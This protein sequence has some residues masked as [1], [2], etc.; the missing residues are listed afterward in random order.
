[1]ATSGGSEHCFR[2]AEAPIVTTVTT[3]SGQPGEYGTVTTGLGTFHLALF[4]QPAEYPISV[5]L[6]QHWTY[7][8]TLLERLLREEPRPAHTA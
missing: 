8:V 7:C 2:G 3:A 1:M 5:V 6:P 4:H